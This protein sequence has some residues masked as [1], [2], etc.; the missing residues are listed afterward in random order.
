M[1]KITVTI[2]ELYFRKVHAGLGM[3]ILKLTSDGIAN[4]IINKNASLL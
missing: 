4:H 3:T 1:I 2:Q